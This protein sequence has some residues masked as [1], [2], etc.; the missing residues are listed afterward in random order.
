MFFLL[1]DRRIWIRIQIREAQKHMDPENP[2]PG[3]QHCKKD[4][5][6][7]FILSPPPPPNSDSK[8]AF[9]RFSDSYLDT[10]PPR[11]HITKNL[12]YNF[13]TECITHLLSGRIGMREFERQ[14]LDWMVVP[15]PPPPPAN[16]ADFWAK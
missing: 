5:P 11:E 13:F 16:P 1:V 6:R 9:T 15:P 8:L 10:V 7:S 3:P 14:G 2:D 12:D 4:S